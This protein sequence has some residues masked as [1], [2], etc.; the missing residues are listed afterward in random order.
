MIYYPLFVESLQGF[1]TKVDLLWPE[2]S[3]LPLAPSPSDGEG[4]RG[5]GAYFAV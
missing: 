3:P 1:L 2:S 5:R 4:E